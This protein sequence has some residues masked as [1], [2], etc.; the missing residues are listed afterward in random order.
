[1]AQANIT[2]AAL[3]GDASFGQ[4]TI[5]LNPDRLTIPVGRASKSVSK[6]ILGAEY[7]AWFDSPV[8]SREHAELCLNTITVTVRDLGSMHGTFL[9]DTKV[10]TEQPAEVEDGDVIAFGAEV[11][12][13][14]EIFPACSFQV[15]IDWSPYRTGSTFSFPNS[16][17]IE[18]EEGY[19]SSNPD[20]EER[21]Q[22]SSDGDA[23]IETPQPIK[24]YHAIAAIDL[25][26][27]DSPI[28]SSS[29]RIDL[30][31]DDPVGHPTEG[32]VMETIPDQPAALDRN[33]HS[34]SDNNH[35]QKL[36]ALINIVG[37]HDLLSSDSDDEP[38]E[39]SGS[40]SEDTDGSDD[41]VDYGDEE[42]N[43]ESDLEDGDEIDFDTEEE[44]FES[45]MRHSFTFGSSQNN[46]LPEDG[47]SMDDDNDSDFGLSEAGAEGLKALFE[48]GLQQSMTECQ[49]S[50]PTTNAPA[51]VD[52]QIGNNLHFMQ[53]PNDISSQSEPLELIPEVHPMVSLCSPI[54]ELVQ[55][56]LKTKATTMESAQFLGARQPS[57]SD[58]A[59]AKATSQPRP[60]QITNDIPVYHLQSQEFSQLSQTLGEKTGKQAF[61]EAREKNKAKFST[62]S[63]TIDERSTEPS[64]SS[65]SAL[66][67]N[68]LL[69]KEEPQSARAAAPT[70]S[71]VDFGV[72]KRPLNE[73]SLPHTPG[74]SITFDRAPELI[75]ISSLLTGTRTG[76]SIH[77]KQKQA[78]LTPP[79]PGMQSN[80]S[81]E[82]HN[83]PPIIDP[84][85]TLSPEY[86]MTSAVTYNQSKAKSTRS[87]LS[88]HDIIESS[89][90]DQSAQVSGSKAG[91]KRKASDISDVLT[92]EVRAWASSRD[93][94]KSLDTTIP[95]CPP[96][97]SC[98][99]AEPAATPALNERPAKRLRTILERAAFAA[100]GGVAV[101]A[102]LFLSLVATA[103]DFS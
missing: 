92:D 71:W 59:M 47:N 56:P 43:E 55:G 13:G 63:D 16:S 48:D 5:T 98:Q 35:Y 40:D 20:M 39:L 96:K 93:V 18:E 72:V 64:A 66:P 85:A 30:T 91:D 61:F 1:M 62:P 2:L 33:A 74:R 82:L 37:D 36:P 88:I 86:D 54:N 29:T 46:T 25:T 94:S 17:D 102:G 89:S 19:G 23:S 24:G 8:M 22:L 49:E 95:N 52:R 10:P 28:P 7:N 90:R 45:M 53:V 21:G 79:V 77:Y 12:R 100:V 15:N 9:N 69:S 32:R 87:R 70:N 11:R 83:R 57:P 97:I 68:N 4:R 51:E 34:A 80:S 6:G 38:F 103:P 76:K 65:K 31:E 78:G 3:T 101:G 14:P 44:P 50:A 75:N 41:P 99:S 60:E 84:T 26:R 67:P 58:A 27:D 81:P 42:S 73:L